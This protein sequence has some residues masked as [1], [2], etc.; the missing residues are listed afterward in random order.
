MTQL[1]KGIHEERPVLHQRCGWNRL[2][3][4]HRSLFAYTKLLSEMNL[5]EQWAPNILLTAHI[6]WLG[7]LCYD[8]MTW[9][10]WYWGPGKEFRPWAKVPNIHRNSSCLYKNRNLKTSE[11]GV[12]RYN[13]EYLPEKGWQEPKRRPS[14]SSSCFPAILVFNSANGWKLEKKYQN[15]PH[16][17]E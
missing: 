2:C 13:L 4:D 14:I 9:T 1:T 17:Y 6:N 12:M 10:G 15:D 7:R 8:E 16:L 11:I 3:A 5:T